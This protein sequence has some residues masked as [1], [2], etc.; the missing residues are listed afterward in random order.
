[1]MN[2]NNIKNVNQNENKTLMDAPVPSPVKDPA[3]TADKV[4]AGAVT[5]AEAAVSSAAAAVTT[6]AATTEKA[7]LSNGTAG[8][9]GAG[10][11]TQS[12]NGSIMAGS[13]QVGT[14]DSFK[15]PSTFIKFINIHNI[16]KHK[17][18]IRARLPDSRSRPR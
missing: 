1:M 4:D 18:F 6:A 12:H 17:Y 3:D 10:L 2:N 11:V 16:F 8:G 14:R 7:S 13:G 5:S 9:A 15:H